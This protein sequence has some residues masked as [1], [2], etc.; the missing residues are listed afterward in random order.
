MATD[1]KRKAYGINSII[2]TSC[3]IAKDAELKYTGGGRAY[4]KFSVGYN[5]SYTSKEGEVVDA[6]YWFPCVMW[7]KQAEA[8]CPFLKKGTQLDIAGKLTQRTYESKSFFE[9][10]IGGQTGSITL[11]NSGKNSTKKEN[12]VSDAAP[13]DNDEG[14]LPADDDIPF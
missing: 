5:D 12:P 6:M 8:L 9:I 11:R 7:G 4:T 14:S 13:D 3:F 1:S 10:V 2:V